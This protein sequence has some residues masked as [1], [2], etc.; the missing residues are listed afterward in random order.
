MILVGPDNGLLAPAVA[1]LGGAKRA[2]SLTNDELHLSA[3]G[4]TFAGRDL[5]APVAA[6]LAAGWT[7]DEVGESIDPVTLLP[8]VVPLTRFENEKV[9]GEALWVD[10]F[11]NIQLNIGP[12]EVEPLGDVLA[13][14]W[15]AKTRIAKVARAYGDIHGGEVGLVVD[16]YGLLSICLDRRNASIELGIGT[17]TAITIAAAV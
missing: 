4:A 12:E 17:S 15:G 10:H 1:M 3:P 11:G 16:S 6:R 2:V 7:L 14:T 13:V 5:F 8:G 9:Y